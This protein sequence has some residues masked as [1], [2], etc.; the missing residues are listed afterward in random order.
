VVPKTRT[1]WWLHKIGTNISNDVN[2]ESLLKAAGWNVI[3]VWECTI[4]PTFRE[5]TLENILVQLKKC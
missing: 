3:K 4:K 1:E 2:A 5:K